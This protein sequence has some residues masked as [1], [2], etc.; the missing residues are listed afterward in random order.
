MPKSVYICEYNGCGNLACK[1][2]VVI[3]IVKSVDKIKEKQWRFINKVRFIKDKL[4]KGAGGWGWE[5]NWRK[6]TKNNQR[7]Y[8]KFKKEIRG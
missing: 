4:K 5:K 6:K 7:V 8:K 1:K 2:M 3:D